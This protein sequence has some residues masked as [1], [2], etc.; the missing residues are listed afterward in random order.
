[1]AALESLKLITF[2]ALDSI[3][4]YPDR[5]EALLVRA[6]YTQK[7]LDPETIRQKRLLLVTWMAGLRTVERK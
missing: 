1:M 2:T 7:N 5:M 4:R 3:S 6:R